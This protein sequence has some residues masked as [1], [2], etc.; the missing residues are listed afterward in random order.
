MHKELKNTGSG[1]QKGETMSSQVIS[2][3]R[4]SPKESRQ[5][6]VKM[7]EERGTVTVMEVLN[8]RRDEGLYFGPSED[9][10]DF[11]FSQQE[12]GKLRIDLK[13]K[14]ISPIRPAGNVHKKVS[15]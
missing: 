12:Q 6:L 15:P 13:N 2:K 5:R 4:L 14:T 1:D 3:S 9:T 10:V 8:F 11:L 7:I